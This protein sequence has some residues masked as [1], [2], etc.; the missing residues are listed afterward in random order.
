[1]AD[2]DAKHKESVENKTLKLK[3]LFAL[4]DNEWLV[5]NYFCWLGKIPGNI[6]ITPNYCVFIS[7]LKQS[8]N[9]KLPFSTFRSVE[10]KESF[11]SKSVIVITETSNYSFSH[12]VHFDEAFYLLQY[13]MKNPQNLISASSI[14][15][16][17]QAQSYG[18]TLTHA[19][20]Q[21]AFSNFG[22]PTGANGYPQSNPYAADSN[23][24]AAN[25]NPYAQGN[26]MA[27]VRVDTQASAN[28]VRSLAIACQYG[29]E[30]LAELNAQGE[31]LNRIENNV[32]AIHYNIDQANVH[33]KGV[34]SLGG[35]IVNMMGRGYDK[36][37]QQRQF[38]SNGG[39]LLEARGPQ[40]VEI[41]RKHEDTTLAPADLTINDSDFFFRDSV[42]KKDFY[43]K[44]S[45]VKEIC[46]RN[47]AMHMDLRF[48]NGKR[49]RL[50][51]GYNQLITNEFFL[52]APT[53]L[54]TFETHAIRFEFGDSRLRE[55]LSKGSKLARANNAVDGSSAFLRHRGQ[56]QI[57]AEV[58]TASDRYKADLMVQEQHLDQ[59]SDYL[60]D[61]H[62]MANSI[63]QTADQQ[64]DQ[65]RRITQKN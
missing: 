65:I 63:G 38:A 23:P 15:N 34:D 49:E 4:P 21:T 10:K 14:I 8:Q 53:I 26:Q 32:D 11:L 2:K 33:L 61:L 60:C 31:M 17:P 35:Q 27:A 36:G 57:S 45:E 29:S 3:K 16:N 43:Y 51:S 12:F 42:E 41:L 6:Y 40:V 1:M 20:Q 48:H 24:Y 37:F 18:E 28:A 44:Y 7:N 22:A 54:V 47:R 52:R 5:Q 50:V 39:N 9:E 19:N 58:A 56:N 62:V 30:T 64:N 25:S 59:I 13:I 55:R 46:L